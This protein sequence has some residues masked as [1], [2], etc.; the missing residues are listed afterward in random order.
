MARTA[1]VRSM[2]RPLANDGQSSGLKRPPPEGRPGV[3]KRCG[4]TL[5]WA[6]GQ[7]FAGTA[8]GGVV[9]G[10]TNESKACVLQVGV[11]SQGFAKGG[12]GPPRPERQAP[13]TTIYAAGPGRSSG[14][15][16]RGSGFW[17]KLAIPRPTR[18]EPDVMSFR[19][20]LQACRPEADQ[21][22]RGLRP[23]CQVCARTR[24]VQPAPGN[25]LDR[26][27]GSRERPPRL[28]R[29]SHGF[30]HSIQKQ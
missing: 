10:R 3:R 23:Q 18:T 9:N 24:F 22:R 30:V 13:S 29:V 14:H 26:R 5:P 15:S 16:P 20:C 27:L 7:V 4:V 2:P 28:V 8:G 21:W 19:P 25:P 6:W 11:E 1:V 12:R 17:N